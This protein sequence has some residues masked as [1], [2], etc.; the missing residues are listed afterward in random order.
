MRWLARLTVAVA[1]SGIA[2]AALTVAGWPRPKA[3][4][5]LDATSEVVFSNVA[6]ERYRLIQ[7][8]DAGNCYWFL[9]ADGTLLGPWRP[10]R[11]LTLRGFDA[12]GRV[13]ADT[14]P[15]TR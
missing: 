7:Q 12:S 1:L 11:P 10:G 8:N 3:V 14:P 13:V 15:T 4:V 2:V 9:A 6:D 5:R